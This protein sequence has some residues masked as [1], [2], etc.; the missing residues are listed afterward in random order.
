MQTIRTKAH[1]I[2]TSYPEE[3]SWNSSRSPYFPC[4]LSKSHCSNQ[5]L[6]ISTKMNKQTRMSTPPKRPCSIQH[7]ISQ[8]VHITI[9]FHGGCTLVENFIKYLGLCGNVLISVL[10]PILVWY[11]VYNYSLSG[12]VCIAK[13]EV[14]GA[15]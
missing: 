10:M 3:N 11:A 9:I 2:A 14:L 8:T 6:L 12:S 15:R 1:P 13:R 4:S 5:F 7:S